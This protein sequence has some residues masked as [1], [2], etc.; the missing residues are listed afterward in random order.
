MAD[1]HCILHATDR[2]FE[3]DVATGSV[4]WTF[5]LEDVSGTFGHG[6]NHGTFS[7]TEGIDITATE[8]VV[9]IGGIMAGRNPARSICTS[10]R[11]R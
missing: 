6:I 9:Y 11:S 5:P 1:A 10:L 7:W 2:T 4:A 8:D 3:N